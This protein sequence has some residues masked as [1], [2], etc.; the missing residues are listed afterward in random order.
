MKNWLATDRS[1]RLNVIGDAVVLFVASIASTR[2]DASPAVH[3]LMSAGL[4]FGSLA[5]WAF[6]GRVVRHYDTANGRRERG[7]FVMTML[8]VAMAIGA[9][10]LVRHF[11]PACRPVVETWRFAVVLVPGV[12]WIRLMTWLRMRREVEP[13]KVLIVGASSL[14]RLTGH[15]LRGQVKSPKEI[16]GYLRFDDEPEAPRVPG[17][18]LGDA[19]ALESIIKTRELDEV[20]IAAHIGTHRKQMQKAISACE[21]FGIPFALPAAGF[22]L[23]RAIALGTQTSADG[24]MH[25]LSVQPKPVQWAVKRA[26]DIVASATALLLLSPLLIGTAL[27]IKLTSK[28]PVLFKQERVGLHGRKFHMLKF[29]SMVVNAEELR[30]KLAAKNEQTGPGLQDAA[31]PAHHGRSAASSASSASTS[32]R[33]SSTCSAAR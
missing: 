5:V 16:V 13:L 4:A 21:R 23:D 32:C 26:F 12:L 14:G 22:R 19:N 25:Y 30:A 10:A 18:V 1:Q 24:Y 2:T 17:E 7:D 3:P 29:R 20:Y 8:L 6:A 27:A 33:S 9:M 31:R 15:E 11:V 28:G